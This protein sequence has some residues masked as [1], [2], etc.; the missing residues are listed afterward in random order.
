MKKTTKLKPL[1]LSKESLRLLDKT[2]LEKVAGG[3]PDTN[4]QTC[5]CCKTCGGTGSWDCGG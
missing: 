4:A 5:S 1:T 3:M 2:D